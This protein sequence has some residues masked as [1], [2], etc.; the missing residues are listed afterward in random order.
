LRRV[1]ALITVLLIGAL[2]MWA[3][4]D[5]PP[6]GDADTPANTYVGREYVEVSEEEHHVSNVVTAVLA[7]YRGLDT[8]GECT[9]IFTAGIAV[10]LLMRR[11]GRL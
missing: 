2:L 6:F 5:I 9:V 3:E 8:L 10:M 11:E 7:S 4:G 1:V